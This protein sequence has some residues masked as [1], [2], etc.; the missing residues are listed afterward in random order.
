LHV[1]LFLDERPGAVCLFL[2][3]G[4]HR[5]ARAGC[6]H[7]PSRS[8]A[9]AAFAAQDA[10]A[11][12]DGEV[13]ARAL[14]LLAFAAGLAAC[15]LDM[16]GTR[17]DD[18][19]A[20]AGAPG[21][22]APPPET[23]APADLDAA[24]ASDVASEGMDAPAGG[25]SI[26]Y[27]RADAP[28]NVDLTAE[29]VSDWA[30]WGLGSLVRK[31][32]VTAA[33][34]DYVLTG[35][36]TVAPSSNDPSTFTWTNGTPTATDTG[37]ST[38]LFFKGAVNAAVTITVDAGP[39]PRT[40]FFYLGLNRTRARF[41]VDFTD[42]SVAT[43]TEEP[44]KTDGALAFRYAVTFSTPSAGAKLRVRWTMLTIVDPLNST[45]RL[46]AVTLP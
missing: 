46:C 41:E 11:R 36:P 21:G 28:A 20:S 10:T 2:G 13:Q 43:Q 45:T 35:S 27:A 31:T 25:P 3:R 37:T 32:G 22:P 19:V 18:G 12:Y 34:S 7:R 24:G 40:A 1:R 17:V 5:C 33:I 16:A 38:H 30:F 39:K 9:D 8:P 44:E 29:G 6:A 26:T 14:S 23:T 4:R 15:G 42:G